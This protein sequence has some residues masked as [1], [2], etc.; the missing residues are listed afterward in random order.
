MAEFFPTAP[1]PPTELGRLRILA[2]TAGVRVSPLQLGAMSLGSAWEQS[3]GS[4]T[5]EAAFK[6]YD[7][8]FEAGGNFIDTANMYQNEESEKWLGEWMAERK[9]RD[10][11][12]IATKYTFDYRN[13]TLG[14]PCGKT[15]NHQGNHRRSMYMSV[16]DSL[17]KLQTDYIDILYVHAWDFTT[18]IK[19]LMDSMQYLVSERKVLYLGVSDTPAWIVSAANG[20]CQHSLSSLPLF[21]IHKTADTMTVGCSVCQ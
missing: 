2:S 7:A 11:L 20:M 19:E 8:F 15:A 17:A 12:V 18:S 14:G 16:R 10:Q 21:W 3:L 4:C 9:N 13:Y 1:E 5:K 6:L